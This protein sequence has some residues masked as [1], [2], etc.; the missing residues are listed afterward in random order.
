MVNCR[1]VVFAGMGF[2]VVMLDAAAAPLGGE[3][4]AEGGKRL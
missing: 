1:N 3:R 2:A 4:K